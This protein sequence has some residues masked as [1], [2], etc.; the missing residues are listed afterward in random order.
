MSSCTLGA[1]VYVLVLYTVDSWL[2]IAILPLGIT[3]YGPLM[4]I[5]IM[6]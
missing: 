4:K 6:L 3:L 5:D 1:A 2:K